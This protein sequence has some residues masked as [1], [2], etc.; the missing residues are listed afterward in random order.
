MG[1]SNLSRQSY[2]GKPQLVKIQANGRIKEKRQ[3]DKPPC[4]FLQI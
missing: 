2:H 4:L 3:G 1:S